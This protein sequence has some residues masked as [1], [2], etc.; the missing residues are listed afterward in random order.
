MRQ[1][2]SFI[3]LV[4]TA[5]CILF[6]FTDSVQA[7]VSLPSCATCNNNGTCPSQATPSTCSCYSGSY[8][9]NCE[10]FASSCA[11]Y[12]VEKLQTNYPFLLNEFTIAGNMVTL[13]VVSPLVADRLDSTFFFNGTSG[14]ASDATSSLCTYPFSTTNWNKNVVSC[15]DKFTAVMNWSQMR[16]CGSW[17]LD[18]TTDPTMSIY[19]NTLVAQLKK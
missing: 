11:F 6:L 2:I 5:S 9:A 7:Q 19:T 3:V 10:L 8:G 16:Q 4:L 12:Q 14:S 18:T 13:A 15:Q 17:N 1:T